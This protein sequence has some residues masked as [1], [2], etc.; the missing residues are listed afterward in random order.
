MD[1]DWETVVWIVALVALTLLLTGPGMWSEKM[2]WSF[3][4]RL[5]RRKRR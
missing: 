2:G 4:D 3:F 1:L 5:F